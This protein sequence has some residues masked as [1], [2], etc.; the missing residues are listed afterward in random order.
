MLAL[1]ESLRRR[2]ISARTLSIVQGACAFALIGF[3]LYITVFDVQDL[4][5]RGSPQERIHFEPRPP[6]PVGMPLSP[7]AAP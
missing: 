4:P 3:M 2:P 7:G 6:T 1:I 5:W